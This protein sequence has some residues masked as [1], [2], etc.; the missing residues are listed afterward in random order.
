MERMKK[1][2]ASLLILAMCL[3]M[4]LQCADPV[5]AAEEANE[6][7]VQLKDTENGVIQFKD[8]KER[9][10]VYKSKDTVTVRIL[11]E[12]GFLPAQVEILDEESQE[13]V[14]SAEWTGK[15]EFSFQMPE[16]NVVITAGFE[17][18]VQEQE[19]ATE[20]SSA[21]GLQDVFAGVE[22]IEAGIQEES[23]DD[24]LRDGGG[25]EEPQAGKLR[26]YASARSGGTST[27]LK[28]GIGRIQVYNDAN[29]M[30]K[31]HNEGMLAVN[32]T[33]AFCADPLAGFKS[34]SVTGVD[35]REYGMM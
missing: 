12:E 14:I 30:V 2:V 22:D 17:P 9:T 10:A 28:G 33:Q 34:G 15:E 32:G 29:V 1:G 8:S 31:S 5:S 18:A 7:S 11:P 3:S 16:K 4:G 25:I 23:G 24:G 35:P 26:T 19:E 6:Y 13:E 27:Q 21:G 20:G